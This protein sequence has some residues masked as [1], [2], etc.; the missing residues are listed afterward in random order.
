M[1]DVTLKA[2]AAYLFEVEDVLDKRVE[3]AI[4]AVAAAGYRI[5][6][7][8]QTDSYEPDTGLA[9]WEIT[10]YRTGELLASGKSA[11]PEGMDDC[12]QDTWFHIDRV[13]EDLPDVELSFGDVPEGLLNALRDE[14]TRP[15]VEALYRAWVTA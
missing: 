2:V 5:V 8:G 4:A 10:D 9:P 15:A 3:E 6:S 14:V 11:G 7:G 1:S 12:W 13:G